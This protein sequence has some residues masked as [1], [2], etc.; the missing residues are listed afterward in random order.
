M[1]IPH[2]K[3]IEALVVSKLPVDKIVER[4]E[5]YG[6]ET[7]EEALPIII[8]TIRKAKPEYF[9]GKNPEPVDPDFLQEELNVM[10]GY[11][12]I[13]GKRIRRKHHPIDG[14]VRLLTDPLM[15][16]LVSSVALAGMSEVEIEL[17]SNGKYNM[18][19]GPEDIKHFLH[20]F[21]NVEGWTRK[22]KQDYIRTI[23]EPQ[24]TYFYNLALKGDKEF[25]MWKLGMAPQKDYAEMLSD[26]VTDAYYNFKE[27]SRVK[28][29]IAQKWGTLATRLIDKEAGIKKEEE[30]SMNSLLE[31]VEFKVKIYSRP[32]DGKIKHYTQLED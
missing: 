31:E 15:F 25:L 16:R 9:D 4:L 5:E 13:T 23:S 2:I 24:L 8:D 3:F 12:F 19:Y 29:E 21:F 22:Q 32:E 14:A 28:P 26:M 7:V 10:E 1:Q 6:L 27:Q 11:I 30:R 18:E 17:I 20:Y